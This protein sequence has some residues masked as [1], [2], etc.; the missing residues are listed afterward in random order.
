MTAVLFAGPTLAGF[1][2]RIPA[3][4]IC[5]PPAAAGDLARALASGAS[6]IGLIDGVFGDCRSVWHKEILLALSQGVPVLGAASMGAL[7]AAEC[8]AFGMV[9]VGGISRDYLTGKRTAD[10][11]VAVLHG[12]AELAFMPLTVALVDAEDRIAALC[13]RG[14]L[15]VALADRLLSAARALHFTQRTW[16]TI[17]EQADP[18]LA[19]AAAIRRALSA[20]TLRKTRDALRLVGRL[21]GVSFAGPLPNAVMTHDFRRLLAETPATDS[22]TGA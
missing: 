5:N 22:V 21:P 3:T 7:R 1:R 17:L 4:I 19:E 6:R 15:P 14:R 10:A 2:H 18:P 16:D 8:A 9:P 12:P 13:R 11:D 20:G